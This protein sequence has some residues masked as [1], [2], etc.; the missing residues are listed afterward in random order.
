M[1]IHIY[2]WLMHIYAYIDILE[3]GQNLNALIETR[4]GGMAG[5]LQQKSER[6]Y[7]WWLRSCTT[8]DVKNPVNN[9]I[10]YLTIYDTYQLVQ[11][12]FHQRY[13]VVFFPGHTWSKTGFFMWRLLT[14]IMIDTAKKLE[15]RLTQNSIWKSKR[16]MPNEVFFKNLHPKP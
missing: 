16:P 13:E 15:L 3:E 8:W 11:D 14:F 4:H 9:G 12:F 5:S 1:H 2:S 7:C 10:N 6:W